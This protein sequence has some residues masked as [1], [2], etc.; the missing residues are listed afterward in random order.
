MRV[1]FYNWAQFD[2]AGLAGGGV[3][4]YLRNVIEELLR[5][6]GVE[7]WFLS[8][9]RKYTGFNRRPRIVATPNAYNHP[10]LKT[11]TLLN[12]PVKAPAHDAFYSIDQ[13][14]GDDV[15]VGLI[16]N[17]LRAHG[18][19]DAVHLHNLE[20]VGARIL[21]LPKDGAMK[22]LFYTFHNYMPLCPQIEL[23]YDGR[24]PCA[25]FRDGYRCVGC[26]GHENR[27]SDLISMA[28]AGSVVNVSRLA[29]HPL[30]GFLFDMQ[31]A[32]HYCYKAV[33]NL[34]N[35]VRHGFKTRFRYWHLRPRSGAGKLHGW[36]AEGGTPKLA[37]LP[38]D[39]RAGLAASYRNWRHSNAAALAENLDG[40]FAVS[41]V[42]RT[43]ALRLLPTG[44]KIETLPL[45]IDLEI[46]VD[47]RTRLRARRAGESAVTVSFVG[48]DI[49]SKGLPF[50][51][52]ALADLDDPFY[53][54]SVNLL[55]V[56]RLGSHRAR[57]LY[58]LERQ[59]KSV[60]VVPS[61]RRDQLQELSGKIDL[62]V[63]PSIW[64]E[65]FNQVTVELARLGVPSLVSSTVGAKQ[66]ITD[67]ETFVF[68]SGNAADFRQKLDALVKEAALRARFF[69]R[70]LAIP[71]VKEH[72]DQLLE[73][74]QNG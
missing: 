3:T 7:V 57:Q 2:D 70:E 27:M 28:R 74:Y 9:G 63:V 67:Q 47:E 30:G 6:E 31:A 37:V 35:D 19:F 72:V 66:A 49:P 54:E 65:T 69:E 26:L 32:A 59:F 40:V 45:P 42:A 34:S 60:R 53:R 46:T 25:D 73:R 61:Y 39:R 1:L 56:A 41:E 64:W 38:L 21:R 29:G 62:N 13:W 71:T 23:L 5:R 43:A 10:R 12:S 51:I 22:R 24:Q 33:R 50:L 16:R 68:E 55:V 52:D 8:A 17:F 36:R 18:P 44:A 4:V 20:G 58:Q 15:S 11:Y 48:Y 14:C